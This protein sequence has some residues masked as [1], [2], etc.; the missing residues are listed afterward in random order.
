MAN[1]GKIVQVIGPVVDV[2]FSGAVPAIYE[3]L[4]IEFTIEGKPAKLTL[5]TQQHLG[6]GWIRA[7]AMSSTEGLKRGL[8]VT[9]TGA[10]ISVP[11]GEGVLGRIFNVLGEPTD[12][13][14]PVTF[15]KKYPIHRTAPALVDQDT[16]STILETGIKVI[17]LICPF[18]KGGKVGAFG[19]AGVGKTVV[20]MELINN[21]AKAHGGYSVFAG[22][23]ERTREGNDL[24]HEM[25][26]SGVINLEKIEESKV[27]L[28]YG[29]MNEP[30][31][32]RL[33]VA[34]SGLAMAEYFRDEK[35]QDVL[36]FV[37]NIFRFSQAGAEV[38]ALLGRTPSAVGY[39]P[40]LASEM[41]NLQERIT[42]TKNGSITSFQA[43]YVPADDLTDPA[44]ANTFAHLDSTIVLERSIAELGIYPA[45]DPLA[46][47]S[48][49]LSPDIIGEEHYNVARGVQKVLQRYKELQDIIA[50]LGM[51]EL[52]EEDKKTVY[53]ARKIQR[54]LSQP[55]HVAEIF[56]GAKGQYVPIAETI[57]GFKEI[58]EGKHDALSEGDF[59]MK[60]D[61][62]S[63]LAAK[64]AK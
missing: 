34:L 15:T 26:E 12:E 55:F 31:G 61:M 19:G 45:V 44:P 47:T 4:E 60:G 57:R 39:Q 46:S 22:V 10:P 36:L 59:Y 17:D 37:D 40:T 43:V 2:E 48:K 51:D 29:Q 27:A 63:V 58:L 52:S 16:G 49:A 33:R 8:P 32:A 11:V 13:R 5:E 3:A 62:A 6:Q 42:S 18:T 1:Q 53:R 23:G 56:T 9:A 41:G 14:G 64:D 38:S 28:V 30:P 24:Y 20:I 35:N 7:I 50:I 25:A 21:I 54:F